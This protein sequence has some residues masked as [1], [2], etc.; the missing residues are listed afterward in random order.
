[1]TK[2][3][4]LLLHGS[5]VLAT[6][7]EPLQAHLKAQGHRVW[8]PDA[9][10]YAQAQGQPAQ[11]ARSSAQALHDQLVNEGAK[12]VI[13]IGHSFG[14]IR[15]AY[16]AT[17]ANPELHIKAAIGLGAVA[18]LDEAQRPGM[19]QL[20][21]LLNQGVD[22]SG[23]LAQRW[24]GAPHLQ[25]HPEVVTHIKDMIAKIDPAAIAVEIEDYF[26]TE[27]VLDLIGA[28]TCPYHMRVGSLDLA[29]PTELAQTIFERAPQATLTQVKGAGHMLVD[30]DQPGTFA[31]I[32]AL[33]ATA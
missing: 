22:L 20:V 17:L 5:G 11:D 28:M 13:L 15:M 9:S 30:E 12:E 3:D 19:L 32:D 25:A 21:E 2:A 8:L 31:W 18:G 7:L 27:E 4:I 29:T 1:M 16:L 33:I 24:Y 26:H 23:P 10:G 14:T 6:T